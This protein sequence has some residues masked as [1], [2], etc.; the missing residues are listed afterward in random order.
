MYYDFTQEKR[1]KHVFHY[2]L[3]HCKSSDMG[4]FMKLK[5]NPLPLGDGLNFFL[6]CVAFRRG[7]GGSAFLVVFLKIMV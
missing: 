7:T 6:L 2:Y 3:S 4:N 5:F 1:K